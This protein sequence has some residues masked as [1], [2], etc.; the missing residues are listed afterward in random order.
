MWD[1]IV[2]IPDHAVSIYTLYTIL[3]HNLIK[4]KLTNLIESTF[5][6]INATYLACNGRHA[7]FTTD[8]NLKK[9]KL[10]SCQTMSDALIC[11]R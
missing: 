11:L 10:W 2:L 3:P 4:D 8:T 1:L 7:F 6:T 9:V 5:Q